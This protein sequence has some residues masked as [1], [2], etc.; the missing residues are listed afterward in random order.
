M[1]WFRGGFPIVGSMEGPGVYPTHACPEPELSPEQLLSGAKWRL[2]A[3]QGNIT[4]PNVW[5]SREESLERVKKGWLNGPFQV[6][7]EG[8][9]VTVDGPK[10]VNPAFRFGAQQRQKLRASDDSKRS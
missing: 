2:K 6:D 9:Y 10:L 4:D 8:R 7:E 5:V 1:E 3:R